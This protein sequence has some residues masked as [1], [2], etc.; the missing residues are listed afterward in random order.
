MWLGLFGDNSNYNNSVCNVT[1]V[2]MITS[3][4]KKYWVTVDYSDDK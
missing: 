4:W 1:G 3:Q 2:Q